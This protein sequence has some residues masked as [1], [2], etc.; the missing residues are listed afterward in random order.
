MS[1][2]EL[3]RQIHREYFEA[4]ADIIETNTFNSTRVAMADY[5]MRNNFV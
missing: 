1:Q 2:P 3:I 4:G 5:G